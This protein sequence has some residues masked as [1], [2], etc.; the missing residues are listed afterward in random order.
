[1]TE[2]DLLAVADERILLIY[3]ILKQNPS[4]SSPDLLKETQL[5]ASA[6]YRAPWKA[7]IGM[8]ELRQIARTGSAK[9]TTK[10]PEEK[11]KP[12]GQPIVVPCQSG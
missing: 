3:G 7:G 1:M 8:T 2:A 12:A 10:A 6:V 9:I 5:C 11:P 4:I